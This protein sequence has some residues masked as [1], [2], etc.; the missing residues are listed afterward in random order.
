MTAA[1]GLGLGNASLS[2]LARLETARRLLAEVR[3]VDE[4]KVIRD[5][6]EAAR[7]YARQARLGLEAQNDAAEIRLR[8]ERKLGEILAALPKQDGGD[9]ARA[10]SHDATE[11][12]P[13]LGD[14]GISKTQS[15]RWQAIAA[16]PEHV[17]DRHVADVREQGR[18]DGTTELT[19]AGAILL[20]RQYRAHSQPPM[21]VIVPEQPNCGDRF[22][23]ADGAALPWPE[24]S[25]DLTV[26]SPPYGLGL[27]Y[28]GGDPADYMA[29]L[30]ALHGWLTE[31]FRVAHPDWGR[32]CLNVP[33]DRDLGGWQPVSAEAIHVARAVG[34]QF[35]TWLLWDK[36]QA[37]A[38]TDR[39]RIDSATAPNVTAPVESVLV[40]YRGQWKRSGPA[41]MPHE[42][43]LELCGP[44]ALWRFPGTS[45]PLC[46]A[47]F[48]EQL[49]ERCITLFSFPGDVV[50]DPFVGRGTA[51]ALAARL[52]RIAW[53]S[54]RD[55]A[56]VAA[57]QAWMA[58]ERARRRPQSAPC[59]HSRVS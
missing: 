13:R 44:R 57:A 7:I 9:A 15:S 32:L 20:A 38:G 30:R 35:R 54:D 31:L 27:Q 56:C 10:R 3:D 16:V 49:P 11:V 52:G 23:V 58:R 45:D 21:A 59:S 43:W 24:A 26:T 37:G 39:G 4:V 6:A 41:A 1:T 12:P 53:A 19:S 51:A 25:V 18:R 29:W 34:W 8:A 46:P 55:P 36:S 47:P 48:P 2:P 28:D 33:L 5:V 42:V 40:F 17:F 14:L 22:E 50:A